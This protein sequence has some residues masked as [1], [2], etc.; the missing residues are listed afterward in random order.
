LVARGP[1]LPSLKLPVPPEHKRAF[2]ELLAQHGLAEAA[3]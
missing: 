2:E 3:V 1:G